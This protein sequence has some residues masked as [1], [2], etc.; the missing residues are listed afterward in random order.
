MYLQAHP[1]S[2]SRRGRRDRLGIVAWRGRRDLLVRDSFPGT[3]RDSLAGDRAAAG[4]HDLQQAVEQFLAAG[5]AAVE[6]RGEAIG[7]AQPCAQ[8]ELHSSTVV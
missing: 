5:D 4:S 7:A 3:F 8:A 6:I 2:E 1:F